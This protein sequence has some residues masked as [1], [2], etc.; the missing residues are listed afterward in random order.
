MTYFYQFS[1]CIKTD[2][3]LTKLCPLLEYIKHTRLRIF[4]H[5]T[6]TYRTLSHPELFSNP[7]LRETCW[8]MYRAT[9]AGFNTSPDFCERDDPP[10]LVSKFYS[11]IVVSQLG[12]S[13]P[14]TI[15][16]RVPDRLSH[17]RNPLTPFLSRRM[18]QRRGGA[19]GASKC[20]EIYEP[21]SPLPSPRALES[22]PERLMPRFPGWI[23]RWKREKCCDIL[24]SP[25]RE[26]QSV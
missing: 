10:S 6:K 19:W 9:Y 15:C 22:E 2:N 18:R 13:P 1:I 24:S 16:H 4:F 23:S 21:T 25:V 7:E 12:S 20:I 14:W 5:F 8:N 17:P 26:I 11:R 3:T